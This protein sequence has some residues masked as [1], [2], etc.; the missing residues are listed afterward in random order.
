MIVH[1]LPDAELDLEAIG[2]YIARDNPRRALNFMAE[3]REKCFAL[4]SMPLAFPLV[5]RYEKRGVRHR[6]YGNYQI[7][8]RLIGTP[9][10]RIDVLH[11]LHS[12]RDY[13]PILFPD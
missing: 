10:E 2:D 13:L 1:I 12:A 7:F 8:Y 6:V 9:V 4:A 5:P 11:V 3:L